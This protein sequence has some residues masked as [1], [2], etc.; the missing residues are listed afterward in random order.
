MEKKT[1]TL[2]RKG[3]LNQNKTTVKL[4]GCHEFYQH[5][6]VFIHFI[7]LRFDFFLAS[8]YIVLLFNCNIRDPG[9]SI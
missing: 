3:T 4:E 8:S 5:S 2:N 6:L 1:G 9:L 7:Y